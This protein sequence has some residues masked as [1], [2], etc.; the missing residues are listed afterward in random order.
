MKLCFISITNLFL[1][2][3]INK[4]LNEIP[5]GTEADLVYWNRHGI[6]EDLSAFKSTFSFNS[7]MNERAGKTE[8]L[9]LFIKFKRFCEKTL[10]KNN[11]DRIIIL[12]NN[13]AVLMKSY[14]NRRYA[15]RYLIDIRDYSSEH[16]PVFFSLEKQAIINSGM[17]VISSEGFKNFLPEWD[18]VICH[19]DPNLDEEQVHEIRSVVREEGK[20]VQISFIGL[21]R[22][23]DQNK[24][25]LDLLGNDERFILAFY[26]Q[27]SER[28][29]EYADEKGIKNTIFKGRF[30]PK[31]TT[32]FYKETDIINN[33]YGNNSPVLDYALSNKLY[34]AAYFNKPI[35]VCPDTLMSSI[36]C[37]HSFGIAFDDSTMDADM[38][39]NK[40]ISIDSEKM[41]EG[42]SQFIEEVQHDNLVF[43]E[44]LQSFLGCDNA[45]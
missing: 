37:S 22:F 16:N 20:P 11:Y 28:L 43:R 17:A 10:S 41:K 9:R 40:Y 26:G 24:R 44:K 33:Y 39:Y 21:V 18:Y 32:G 2:P 31:E 4:Y 15:S 45:N 27:N 1:C 13:M 14:L 30:D 12:H 38:L 8:K 29:K 3:Y 23:Y 42:C 6:D 25:L 35:L 7:R 5:D 19:N 36:A 34:Y